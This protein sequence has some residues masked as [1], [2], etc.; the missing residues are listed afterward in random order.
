MIGNKHRF[1]NMLITAGA[2]VLFALPASAADGQSKADKY[3]AKAAQY[4]AQ[5]DHEKAEKY[6]AKAERYSGAG[7]ETKAAKY[8]AKA[9]RYAAAGDLEKAQKYAAKALRYAEE[10]QGESKAA[11]YA[12]KAERYALEGDLDKAARYAEK[13]RNAADKYGAAC[14]AEVHADFS[15]DS[16]SVDVQSNKDL[17]NVVLLFADGTTERHEGLDGFAQSFSAT[18]DNVGKVLTGI[19]VKSGCNHSG[20]GPGYGEFF[21]NAPVATGLPVVSI[22]GTPVTVELQA[23]DISE[24]M[25]TVSLSEM[26]PLD[27]EPVYVTLSTADGTATAGEDYLAEE[28]VLEFLPGEISLQYSILVIGD[29]AMEANEEGYMV[30]LSNPVNALLGESTAQGWIMDDDGDF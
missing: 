28:V 4:E 16:Y 12:A 30:V 22:T 19:W 23:G 5:G 1:G 3:F 17:S 6:R 21:E 20:D 15:A 26:V 10:D 29:Y 14:W 18:G 2:L 11:K 27:G 13:A 25:F 9:A 7:Y 8:A 24:A